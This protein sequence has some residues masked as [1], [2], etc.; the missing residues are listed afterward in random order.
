MLEC[1][2]SPEAE[3]G[4]HEREVVE[5]VEVA[6]EGDLALVPGRVPE[7]QLQEVAPLHD[8]LLVAEHLERVPAVVLPEP[9]L[10]DA[11][12]REPVDRVL[13]HGVVEGDAPG[14]RLL[15]DPAPERGVPGEG[16]D[17]QRLRH[18]LHERDAVLDLLDLLVVKQRRRFSS[19]EQEMAAAAAFRNVP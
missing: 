5:A 13:H 19:P 16:V 3:E 9:A 18:G 1:C 17:G 8:R 12:E 4:E 7:R 6:H 14:R 10:P 15:H 2:S 11:A